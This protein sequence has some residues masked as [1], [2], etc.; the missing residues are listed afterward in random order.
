MYKNKT[1]YAITVN[2]KVISK[3]QGWHKWYVVCLEIHV[4]AKI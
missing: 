4:H 2:N 1:N 3:L